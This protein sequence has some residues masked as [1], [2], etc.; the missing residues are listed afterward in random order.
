MGRIVIPRVR[1]E[2]RQQLQR[3]RRTGYFANGFG[4]QEMRLVSQLADLAVAGGGQIARAVQISN[5]ERD[6]EQK[7]QSEIDRRKEAAQ[8]E[9]REAQ[10]S[11]GPQAFA[12]SFF[13]D[14][15]G[16]EPPSVREQ[17]RRDNI[18]FGPDG[19]SPM[20]GAP[21]IAS[22]RLAPEDARGLAMRTAVGEPP[23]RK[24]T[25]LPGYD[26]STGAYIPPEQFPGLMEPMG[27][28]STPLDKAAVLREARA[29][30]IDPRSALVQEALARAP[31]FVDDAPLYGEYQEPLNIYSP[32]LEELQQAQ[33]AAQERDFRQEAIEAVGPRPLFRI[34]DILAAAPSARTAEQRAMLLQAA[35]DSPDIQAA[36]LT[37]LAKGAYRDRAMQAVMKLFPEEEEPMSE[38]DMLRMESTR[39]SI[40]TENLRQ[41][42]LQA[43]LDKDAAAAE[44]RAKAA[45]KTNPGRAKK[46]ALYAFYT[47]NLPRK[48]EIGEEAWRAGAGELWDMTPSGLPAWVRNNKLSRGTRKSVNTTVGRLIQM[49]PK[50]DPRPP[51]TTL[52]P[53]EQ[54]RLEGN[55][56]RLETQEADAMSK[57]RVLEATLSN[58]KTLKLAEK[59]GRSKAQIEAAIAGEK[60]KARIAREGIK[61]SKAR[62]EAKPAATPAPSGAVYNAPPEGETE[63]EKF[64]RLNAA[65]K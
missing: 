4:P 44:R 63:Q 20:R 37:D 50:P 2:A 36:N 62:L 33:R 28:P 18:T 65:L 57:V 29:A 43:E 34:A 54:I 26:V 40:E 16:E 25:E 49:R 46:E 3:K 9:M 35:S 45:T 22:G 12:D 14:A 27:A 21:I 61:A 30:G 51:R 42:K 32:R 23:A 64:D 60:K 55:I 5:R 24:V 19:P 17:V 48:D 31:E 39:E 52:T 13:M 58:T 8:A 1:Q 38:L 7:V 11:S 15:S 56:T 59:R 47:K 6:Y 10:M 41:Q 53:S